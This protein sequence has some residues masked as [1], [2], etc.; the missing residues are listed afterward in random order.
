[1]HEKAIIVVFEVLES[2]KKPDVARAKALD[3]LNQHL[4]DGW[5]VKQSFGMG[6]AGNTIFS[7]SLVILERDD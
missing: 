7:T 4:D 2:M 5:R 1:M 6:G 3:E